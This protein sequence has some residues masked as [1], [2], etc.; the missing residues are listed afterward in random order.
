MKLYEYVLRFR[1][2]AS[3]KLKAFR[4]AAGQAGNES[5]ETARKLGRLS[6]QAD[7]TGNSFGRL[8]SMLAGAF[9]IAAL[10]TFA[11]NVVQT[12]ARMD[13]YTNSIRFSSGSAQEAA[14]NTQFLN[15][16]I[17]KAGLNAESSFKSFQLLNGGLIGFK[18][19]GELARETFKGVTM[20][21]SAFGLGADETQGAVLALAQIAGKGKVSMEELRGQLGERI[22]GA[23]QVAARAMGTTTAGLEQMVAK[24]IPAEKFLPRFAAE[25]QKT[26]GSA[27]PEAAQSLSANLNRLVNALFRAANAIGQRFKPIINVLIVDIGKLISWISRNREELISLAK[28]ISA[29]VL[30][31]AT[32]S[33]TV[34]AV[35]GVMAAYQKVVVL[36]R[37]AQVL[38]TRG[39]TMTN[40]ALLA[41]P[42]GLAIAGI[43]ALTAGIIY[44]WNN[45]EGFRGA[46]IGIKE[47]LVQLGQ[48]MIQNFLPV[49]RYVGE[50]IEKVKAGDFVGAAKSAAKATASIG[51][52]TAANIADL[53]T[54]NMFRGV[55]DAYNRGD[56][57][58]RKMGGIKMPEWLSKYLNPINP[59][60]E[61]PANPV[62]PKMEQPAG[63]GDITGGGSKPL[64]V[65][66]SFQKF[67]ESITINA[68]G[69]DGAI[70]EVE[71]KFLDMFGRVIDG[72]VSSVG[73]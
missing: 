3:A 12:T 57:T 50:V 34:M 2:E 66:I 70:S 11:T 51:I 31:W 54:G 73:R 63:M 65:N 55:G 19:Q 23:M 25:L 56:A 5:V 33:G 14:K 30:I 48:N 61:N 45:F 20:A 21:S 9:T 46:I 8:K 40:V 28:W 59:A 15:G 10:S 71:Q 52:A 36:A 60:P 6:A 72:G 42:F 18:N 68:G 44:A 67:N 47:A 49:F 7:L 16:W 38:W 27:M 22:P 24:G 35:T 58:G 13:G 32:Y 62:T 64:V 1:D 4:A 41:N 29:G 26:F 39:I 17:D 53:V 43:A 37:I 69:L